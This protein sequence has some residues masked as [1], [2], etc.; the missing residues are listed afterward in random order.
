MGILDGTRLY[1]CPAHDLAGRVWVLSMG[2]KLYAYPA[3]AG[4]VPVPWVKLTSLIFRL[5]LPRLWACIP[6]L[7]L[8]IVL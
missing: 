3:H 4:M 8:H 1:P 5:W 2:I 6:S 7:P